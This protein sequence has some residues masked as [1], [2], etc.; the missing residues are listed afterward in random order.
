MWGGGCNHE[1]TLSSCAQPGSEWQRPNGFL[2]SR[3]EAPAAPPVQI[4]PAGWQGDV[5]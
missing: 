1:G 2:P 5:V 4:E 3:L